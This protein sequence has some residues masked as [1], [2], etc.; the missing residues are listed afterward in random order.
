M[1]TNLKMGPRAGGKLE[2]WDIQNVGL[3]SPSLKGDSS[4]IEKHR[5]V[6]FCGIQSE[7]EVHTT[8]SQ[9]CKPLILVIQLKRSSETH[10]KFSIFT[11]FYD[12]IADLC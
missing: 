11:P 9:I 3:P 8:H 4:D 10:L 1:N 2:K 12:S 7:A 6:F 5:E